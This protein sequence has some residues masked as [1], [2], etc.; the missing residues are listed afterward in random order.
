MKLLLE[1]FTQSQLIRQVN[2]FHPFSAVQHERGPRKPKTHSQM[3][4]IP[5]HHHL[6]H[7]HR[8]HAAPS[9]HLP[10]SLVASVSASFNYTSH[11]ANNQHKPFTTQTIH[12]P[13]PFTPPVH[14]VH[15]L[16]QPPLLETSKSSAF[17]YPN[18]NFN[19][20]QTIKHL[21]PSPT[22]TN[23]SC[24]VDPISEN[25][26]SPQSISD[27]VNNN[28]TSP[29]IQMKEPCDNGLLELLIHPEKCH[30]FFHY[31]VHNSIVFSPI[32]QN[33]MEI[34]LPS[35]ELLQVILYKEIL[36]K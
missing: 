2:L 7:H 11:L 3:H 24:S 17:D 23:S 18:T 35:W 22:Q 28:I 12:H 19:N 32:A 4:N 29:V 20:F 36:L 26:A 9:H 15:P 8:N 34:S 10:V 1:V 13:Q 16:V 21:T 27:N 6:H 25:L 31:Q 14:T 33:G 5:Q 30:D